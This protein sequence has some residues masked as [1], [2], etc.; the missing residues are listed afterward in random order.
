[1][2]FLIAAPEA[3]ATAASDLASLGS[4]ISTANAA[5]AASTTSV[6]AAG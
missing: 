4:A 5:A 3:I 6:L 2:S 1:M